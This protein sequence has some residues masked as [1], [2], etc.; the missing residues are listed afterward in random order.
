MTRRSGP[1]QPPHPGPL[2]LLFGF[3]TLFRGLLL[4][5]L[6]ATHIVTSDRAGTVQP[7][8]YRLCSII[9]YCLLPPRKRPA[10]GFGTGLRCR[11]LWLYTSM[12]P[13]GRFSDSMITGQNEPS[14]GL[15][16]PQQ[17]LEKDWNSFGRLVFN[18]YRIGCGLL[19][20]SKV[21]LCFFS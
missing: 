17:A 10:E 5:A 20:V 1:E 15:R 19:G 9:P 16:V 6:S 21:S 13:H 18:K 12:L 14:S 7:L 4:S 3:L 2:F 11:E 8:S